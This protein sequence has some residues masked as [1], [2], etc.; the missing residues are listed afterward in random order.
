MAVLKEAYTD[1]GGRTHK[2][3][4]I[5]IPAGDN[6]DRERVVEELF[7]ALTGTGKKNPA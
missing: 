7:Q 1:T 3:E 4:H 2:V 6:A 5:L